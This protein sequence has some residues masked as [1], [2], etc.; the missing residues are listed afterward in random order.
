MPYLPPMDNQR[1]KP[2]T[3]VVNE[4]TRIS[5]GR[6]TAERPSPSG[7]VVQSFKA[8]RARREDLKVGQQVRIEADGDRALRILILAEPVPAKPEQRRWQAGKPLFQF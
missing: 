6:L 4:G 8:E 2:Q 7:G 3:Y 5:I 1:S